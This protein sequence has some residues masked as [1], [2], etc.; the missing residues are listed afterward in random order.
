MTPSYRAAQPEDTAFIVDAWVESYRHAHAAGLIPMPHWQRVMRDAANWFLGQ[1]GVQVVVAELDGML[2]GFVAADKQAT[3][4]VRE[5]K[6]VSSGEVRWVGE[7]RPVTSVL[8]L[9]VKDAFRHHGIGVA[10]MAAVGVY[11]GSG[12]FTYASKTEQGSEFLRRH[13][14]VEGLWKPVEARFPK[15]Q[16]LEK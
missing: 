7:R 11:P 1:P 5:R 14:F 2:A 10:L 16:P 6:R 9:Y 8:Y 4:G 3:T 12:L 13:G 15:K